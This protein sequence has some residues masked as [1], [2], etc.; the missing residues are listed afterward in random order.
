MRLDLTRHEVVQRVDLDLGRLEAGCEFP[1]PWLLF[2]FCDFECL[3]AT[4]CPLL[5]VLGQ[6]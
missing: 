6:V 3:A 4:G 1:P 5:P 2:L